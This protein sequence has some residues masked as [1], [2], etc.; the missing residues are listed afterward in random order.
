MRKWNLN[1]ITGPNS[2]NPFPDLRYQVTFHFYVHK[3]T[4][5]QQW[6]QN[7]CRGWGTSP[8]Q[9]PLLHTTAV[10]F[11]N[12]T[13]DLHQLQPAGYLLWNA[14]QTEWLCDIRRAK[15]DSSIWMT[16]YLETSRA[17]E[18]TAKNHSTLQI[19]ARTVPAIRMNKGHFQ[20]YW[21]FEI[22]FFYFLK[23]LEE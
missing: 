17:W 2:Y 12:H 6:Y 9:W 15:K 16:T 7:S 5:T 3:P 14:H 13:L 10:V 21:I 8:Q 1:S 18:D 19:W 20:M 22:K 4:P 11:S 23:K